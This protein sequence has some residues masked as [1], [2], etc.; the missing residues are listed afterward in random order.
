MTEWSR[1]KWSQAQQVL[2]V[3]GHEGEPGDDVGAPPKA[4]FDSLVEAGR[5]HEAVQ[6]LAQALPRHE[7]VAWAARSVNSLKDQAGP[8]ASA[9]V[10][11]NADAL[12]AALLWVQDPSEPR[13]RKA[14][15]AAELCGD[16][17]GERLAAMAVFFSGG[18]IAPPDCQPVVAPRDAAGR[19]AAGAILVAAGG[20]AQ[21]SSALRA[22]LVEGAALATHGLRGAAA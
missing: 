2:S 11:E 15:A 19:F 4:Y 8:P 5:L 21:G 17:S 13:R 3:L 7:A 22:C 9:R 18:S 16:N 6:F 10:V 14:F 1:V 12:K 20:G